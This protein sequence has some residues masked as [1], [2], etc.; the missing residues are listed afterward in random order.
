MGKFTFTGKNGDNIQADR[1]IDEVNA[2]DYDALLVLGGFSPDLL[3]IYP[4]NSTFAKAFFQADKPVFT[5]YHGPQFLIN[6]DELK[7]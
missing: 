2:K 4:S 7:G 5:I 6:T 3:R 1:G